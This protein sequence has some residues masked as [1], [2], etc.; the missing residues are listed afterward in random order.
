MQRA[1]RGPEAPSKCHFPLS[2]ELVEHILFF[3]DP[4][5]II[6]M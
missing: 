5:D 4:I 1:N 2:M 3:A 6:S